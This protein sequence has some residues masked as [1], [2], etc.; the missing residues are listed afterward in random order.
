MCRAYNYF[1]GPCSLTI[2]VVTA[3][4]EEYLTAWFVVYNEQEPIYR[5]NKRLPKRKAQNKRTIRGWIS[6]IPFL[7]KDVICGVGKGETHSIPTGRPSGHV[8]GV[9]HFR[10]SQWERSSLH[11]F[12]KNRRWSLGRQAPVYPSPDY[13]KYKTPAYHMKTANYL[14]KSGNCRSFK[15]VPWHYAPPN[16]PLK[17]LSADHRQ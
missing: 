6:P 17:H 8:P 13:P 11:C 14:S 4:R 16:T 3:G 2:V 10:S 12:H 5:P 9:T 1:G 15:D 7:L